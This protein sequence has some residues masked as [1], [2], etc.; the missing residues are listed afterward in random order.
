MTED[1]FISA[2]LKLSAE[3]AG[4][5]DA[6]LSDVSSDYDSEEQEIGVHQ[7]PTAPSQIRGGGGKGWG[8]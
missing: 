7:F 8:R 1:A 3:C 5:I 4:G 6:R 2:A